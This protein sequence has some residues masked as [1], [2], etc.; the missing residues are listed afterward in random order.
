MTRH[1]AADVVITTVMK[2]EG[3]VVVKWKMVRKRRT[4][5]NVMMRMMRR[6]REF[7]FAIELAC[8]QATVVSCTPPMFFGETLKQELRSAFRNVSV[9]I[10]D[11]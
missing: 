5:K 8:F 9:S 6:G 2:M 10:L 7:L 4:G 11:V 1:D 3:L